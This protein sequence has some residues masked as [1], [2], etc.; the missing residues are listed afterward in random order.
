MRNVWSS[1]TFKYDLVSRVNFI[2][3]LWLQTTVTEVKALGTRCAA[4]GLWGWHSTC[5]WRAPAPDCPYPQQPWGALEPLWSTKRKAVTEASAGPANSVMAGTPAPRHQAPSQSGGESRRDKRRQ[6][7]R[8]ALQ[9]KKDVVQIDWHGDLT[10][11]AEENRV[12]KFEETF[13]SEFM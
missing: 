2:T 6:P 13:L 4:A 5:L 8:R 1:Y 3:R 11:G 12:F 9:G 7:E 10:E